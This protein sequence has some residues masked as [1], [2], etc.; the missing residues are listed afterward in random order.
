MLLVPYSP[1][2]TAMPRSAEDALR[3]LTP[4][5]EKA[6]LTNQR[7]FLHFLEGRV[8]S[9]ALAEEILQ[10][11]FLR[12]L[13]HGVPATDDQSAVSWFYAVLRNALVDFYRRKGVEGRALEQVAEQDGASAMDPE[14][15]G[16]VCACMHDLL[17]TLK[18][19][20]AD[21]VRR[22]DLEERPVSEVAQEAGITSN[23][24]TVRL[25][26][27]RQALKKQLE[28]SCGSCATHG[29]LDCSCGKAKAELT[30]TPRR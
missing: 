13:E 2:M 30:Y 24:A 8:G 22:V 28:R 15:R 17:P 10:G 25:H 6:L 27:A 4:D 12:A 21:V 14:L 18:P 26:R 7:R 3:P 5:V 9:R 1:G 29:C 20:Y 11:A 19:E 23:N 16:A